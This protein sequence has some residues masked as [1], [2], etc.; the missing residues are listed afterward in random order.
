MLFITKDFIHY[1]AISSKSRYFHEILRECLRCFCQKNERKIFDL[2]KCN[3]FPFMIFFYVLKITLR[4]YV[5]FRKAFWDTLQSVNRLGQI[6]LDFPCSHSTFQNMLLMINVLQR[7]MLLF[8]TL[9]ESSKKN[10][11]YK[12]LNLVP[13]RSQLS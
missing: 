7:P 12:N 6:S 8:S 9:S 3:F 4:V 13:K 10:V 5:L 1:H 11:S 2:R